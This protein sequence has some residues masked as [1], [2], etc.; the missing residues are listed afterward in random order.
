MVIMETIHLSDALG[1][2]RKPP[3]LKFE[4]LKI[5]TVRGR[6][7][8]TG[9]KN[10]LKRSYYPDISH[11]VEGHILGKRLYLLLA[12]LYFRICIHTCLPAARE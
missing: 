9:L 10:E 5:L 12:K 6:F 2:K 11:S 7:S 3:K 4:I 8:K 1:F